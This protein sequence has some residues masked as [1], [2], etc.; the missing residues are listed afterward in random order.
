MI[1]NLHRNSFIMMEQAKPKLGKI[2]DDYEY[3]AELF[4]IDKSQIRCAGFNLVPQAASTGLWD[5]ILPIKTN[6]A[7]NALK[8]DFKA[9]AEYTRVNK[10]GG[11]H[12]FTLDT[13][14]GGVAISRNFCPLYGIDEEAATGTSNG[15]L[16][17]YLFHHNVLNEFNEE[18]TFLQGYSMDR[19]SH[20]ITKL[21]NK[22]NPLVM[23][24]GNSTILTKGEI[25]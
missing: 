2:F 16:T 13:N 19:P 7:L 4:N 1:F 3:L 5:I 17:Y 25:Y 8:P 14:E 22:N 6:E 15:A 18:Y 12:A 11:V 21:V 23:V 24:G 10:V 9:L 20:I